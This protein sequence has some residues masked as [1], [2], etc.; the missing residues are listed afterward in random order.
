MGIAGAGRV[1]QALGR[2]LIECGQRVVAVAGRDPERTAQA[3]RFISADTSPTTIE[4]I[5]SHASHLLI[6]VS[7]DAVENVAL[8]LSRCGFQRGIAL[9]TCGA[10]GPEALAALSRQGVSC[11][12]L[13]PLQSFPSAEEGVANIA[14]SAFAIDGD[15]EAIEWASAITMLVGGRCLRIP[16]EEHTLYHA[17]A[18]MASSYVAALIYGATEILKAV[19]VERPM[20]LSTLTPLVRAATENALK[21]G[22]VEALTGPIQRG[23]SGKVMDHLKGMRRVSNPIRELYCSAGEFTVEMALLRGLSEAKAAQIKQS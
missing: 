14:G 15:P 5:P 21:L 7:D 6:A 9:H 11:G 2:V 10:K 23:E 13:H 8:R 19:G 4:D 17:A 1:A 16:T 22:P 3:A 18:V 20:A 12:T